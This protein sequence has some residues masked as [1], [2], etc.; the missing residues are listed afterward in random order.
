MCKLFQ[1]LVREVLDEEARALPLLPEV[2]AAGGGPPLPPLLPGG[3]GG[4][5]LPAGALRGDAALVHA[6]VLP[7]GDGTPPQL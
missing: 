5:I 7:H 2:G 1:Y 3:L 6:L 4:P